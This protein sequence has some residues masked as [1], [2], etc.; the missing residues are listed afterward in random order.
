MK[1]PQAQFDFAIKPQLCGESTEIQE[2]RPTSLKKIKKNLFYPIKAMIF[3]TGHEIF[4]L[5]VAFHSD[6]E[7][8]CHRFLRVVHNKII[9]W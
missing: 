6:M 2:N 4:G 8:S 1:Q 9:L 3:E 7:V 5:Q